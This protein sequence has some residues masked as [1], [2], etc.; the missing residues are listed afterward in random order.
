MERCETKQAVQCHRRVS[1]SNQS[2]SF[3]KSCSYFYL[4]TLFLRS[5][6][7]SVTALMMRLVKESSVNT[8]NLDLS[9]PSLVSFVATTGA[10]IPF[11]HLSFFDWELWFFA[12]LLQVVC[13]L[14]SPQVFIHPITLKFIF[15]HFWR[16][17][18][19]SSEWFVQYALGRASSVEQCWVWRCRSKVATHI[20][21][22]IYS[23]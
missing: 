1:R 12:V 16:L 11:Y 20:D 22:H 15:T 8:G 17:W 23:L 19:H 7:G 3:F 4:W 9:W 2:V 21:I 13:G 18:K 6:S 14:L 10:V 5:H